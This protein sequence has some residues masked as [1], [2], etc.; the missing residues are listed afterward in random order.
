MRGPKENGFR[1]S[2]DVLFRSAAAHF[3]GRVIGVLLNGMLHDGTAGLSA[4]LP[5]GGT[6]V[7]QNPDDAEYPH[8]PQHAIANNKIDHRIPLG[9]MGSRIIQLV[10][11]P[12]DH[13][14]IPKEIKREAEIAERVV[15]NIEKT[16]ELGEQI[17]FSCPDCGGSIWE[18]SDERQP[19]F[20]C[21]TGHAYNQDGLIRQQSKALEESL[22]IALRMLED[23]CYPP[24]RTEVWM[25]QWLSDWGISDTNRCF[26]L[27]KLIHHANMNNKFKP[28]KK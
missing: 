11:E 7:V 17:P 6:A 9:Q 24:S 16:T 19:R 12:A 25:I 22:W 5:S 28:M 21:H 27:Y 3:D 10:N 18:I 8:M 4:I 20:R 13:T 1:P 23:C 26:S 2:V 14:P 15:T